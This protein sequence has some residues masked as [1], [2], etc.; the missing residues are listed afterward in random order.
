MLNMEINKL[1]KLHCFDK[2]LSDKTLTVAN[3][4]IM[5]DNIFCFTDDVTC[6][7]I[8]HRLLI[9]LYETYLEK[10]LDFFIICIYYQKQL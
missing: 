4:V 1:K 5:N 8:Q 10:P 6:K 7:H 9:P 3:R 2:H